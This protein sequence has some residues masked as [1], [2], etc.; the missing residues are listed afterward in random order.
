MSLNPVELKNALDG[1][2]AFSLTPFASDG[3]LDVGALRDHVE[4]LLVSGATAIFPA[5]GTGEFFSLT[6]REYASVVSACVEQVGGRV[7]V[8]AG[9]GYGTALAREFAVMADESG[10]DGVLVLPPYLIES[11]QAGLVDHYRAVAAASHLGMIVYQRGSTL[12]EPSTLEQIAES[13]NVIGFKDGVGQIERILRIRRQLGDRFVYMNGMP[14]AE[15]YAS[16][17]MSCGV[18]TYSSAILTFIPEV[19]IEFYR[20]LQSGNA[21]SVESILQR[22]VLP[23]AE[24]RNRGVGYAVS[25][26]KAGARLRGVNVGSVRSPLADPR[27]EDV[28]DL[29]QLL[30]QLGL[31]HP[32][33]AT[34]PTHA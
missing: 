14:T 10:A 7:P 34:S 28:R 6:P 15:I 4:L 30:G 16:A 11:P 20:A 22:V 2:L 13:P 8:V 9:A 1:L 19:S 29:A 18:T 3:S 12:F 26:V 21:A 24:I 32:L 17:L 23:F 25:L 31:D 5:G 33:G 27:P